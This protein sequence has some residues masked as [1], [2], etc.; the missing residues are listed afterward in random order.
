MELGLGRVE[1]PAGA[2]G[3][4]EELDLGAHRVEAPLLHHE[5]L[6]IVSGGRVTIRT[7]AL[8]GSRR[9]ELPPAGG[10]DRRLSPGELDAVDGPATCHDLLDEHAVP[11]QLLL[12]CDERRDSRV[13]TGGGPGS[14]RD[15]CPED[16]EDDEREREA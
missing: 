12:S 2:V 15:P 13:G 5:V 3:L 7:A 11:A 8:A 10:R 16:E 14:C 6:V 1:L 4:D 9:R